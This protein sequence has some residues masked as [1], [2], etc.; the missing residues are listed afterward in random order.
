MQYYR[1]VGYYGYRIM[2]GCP[3]GGNPLPY[4]LIRASTGWVFFLNSSWR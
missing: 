1:E 3:L 4:N 2:R